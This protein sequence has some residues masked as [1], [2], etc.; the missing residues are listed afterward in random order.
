MWAHKR[1]KSVPQAIRWHHFSAG[2]ANIRPP[3]VLFEPLR[4]ALRGV[5]LM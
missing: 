1:P 3:P 4:H 2:Q 5:A